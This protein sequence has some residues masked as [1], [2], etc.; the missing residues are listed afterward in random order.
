[1]KERPIA[2]LLPKKMLP[3]KRTFELLGFNFLDCGHEQILHAI[4]PF[5]WR[6]VRS[7]GLW[8]SFIDEK[9]LERG[10]YLF[11]K[12]SGGEMYLLRRY[13][14]FHDYPTGDLHV[15]DCQNNKIIYFLPAC[16]DPEI[17]REKAENFL[18]T[19]YPKWR[20]PLSYWT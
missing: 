3:D 10:R 8:N 5:S 15:K 18:D 13:D 6:T 9:G 11:S 17:L 1:M 14:I 7:E 19:N 4:L 16:G 20:S 2:C 12:L